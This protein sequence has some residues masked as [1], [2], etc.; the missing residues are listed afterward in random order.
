MQDH[1]I[2][3]AKAVTSSW[4]HSG[5]A[6]GDTPETYARGLYHVPGNHWS[7]GRLYSGG[8]D[9]GS[10]V[11]TAHVHCLPDLVQERGWVA[12]ANWDRPPI[13]KYAKW[14]GLLMDVEFD[15]DHDG[16][17]D[18]LR[19]IWSEGDHA[20]IPDDAVFGGVEIDG[21][22]VSSD[23]VTEVRVYRARLRWRVPE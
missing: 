11:D 1:F 12:F 5:N 3:A 14:R 20:A 18:T 4:L 21:H 19:L 15:L 13:I 16:K 6:V 2:Y 9:L 17:P 23:G 7:I 8:E 10:H 22:L